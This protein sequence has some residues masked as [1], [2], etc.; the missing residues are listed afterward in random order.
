M[1]DFIDRYKSLSSVQLY[2][3]VHF[4][5]HKYQDLAVEAAKIE[6][7]SRNLTNDELLEV[8]TK[9]I[10]Q[11]DL[12]EKEFKKQKDKKE[13]YTT[14]LNSFFNSIDPFSS[15]DK[16][17]DKIINLIVL[18]LSVF[19]VYTMIN[20]LRSFYYVLN[21]FSGDYVFY[22]LLNSFEI[23]LLPF[24]LYPFWKRHEKYWMYLS[25]YV[26]Y[27]ITGIIVSVPLGIYYL[28]SLFS[29]ESGMFWELLITELPIFYNLTILLLMGIVLVLMFREDVKKIYNVSTKNIFIAVFNGVA[30]SVLSTLSII[31]QRVY[32]FKA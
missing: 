15:T 30:I 22:L 6:L 19:S 26:V 3:I 13:K 27:L 1:N 17:T 4:D 24:F 8:K 21:E 5:S 32:L 12:E 7:D 28:N 29:D 16:T 25:S 9:L 10:E 18:L 14:I 2:R 23:F 11:L 20:Q 31:L